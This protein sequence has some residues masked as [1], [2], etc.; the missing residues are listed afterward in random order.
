MLGLILDHPLEPS[1]DN[2]QTVYA[3]PAV[4]MLDQKAHAAAIAGT[5]REVTWVIIAL[6]GS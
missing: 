6:G 3:I 1:E 5:A 4:L 2:S